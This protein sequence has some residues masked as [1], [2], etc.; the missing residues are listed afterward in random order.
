MGLSWL[1]WKEVPEQG[2][3]ATHPEVLGIKTMM[4]AFRVIVLIVLAFTGL[5]SVADGVGSRKEYV[6]A[7]LVSGVLFLA[8]I[9]VEALL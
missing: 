9:A 3:P 5:G 4:T 6:S 2:E 8:S 1:L 7:F